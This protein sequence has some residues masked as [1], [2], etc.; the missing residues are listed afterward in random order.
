MRCGAKEPAP[1]R[2]FRK[3]YLF[4]PSKAATCGRLRL[5]WEFSGWGSAAVC[6]GCGD[7]GS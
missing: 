7:D 4:P 5:P 6:T 3:I 1:H 2:H